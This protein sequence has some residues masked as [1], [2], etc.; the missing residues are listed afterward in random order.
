MAKEKSTKNILL[1]VKQDRARVFKMNAKRYTDGNVAK[2]L[3]VAGSLKLSPR[4]A[5]AVKRNEVA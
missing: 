5:A 1:K 4:Q 2:W 3:R